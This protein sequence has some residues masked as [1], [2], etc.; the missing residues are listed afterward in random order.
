M[1]H[2]LMGGHPRLW[3]PR[4]IPSPQAR[5]SYG[6]LSLSESPPVAHKGASGDT[7][8][9]Q[10]VLCLS[11]VAFER[12]ANNR[13]LTEPIK[14]SDPANRWWAEPR[15]SLL[16]R[17]GHTNLPSLKKMIIIYGDRFPFCDDPAVNTGVRVGGMW[18]VDGDFIS[19]FNRASCLA[20]VIILF[21]L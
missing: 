9:H 12:R 2:V 18:V 14:F 11:R 15:T 8:I 4:P 20:F 21:S 5:A 3:F 13:S 16:Q 1:W 17:W 19:L 10:L 6:S 7:I